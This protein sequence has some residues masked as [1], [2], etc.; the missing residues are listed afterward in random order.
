MRSYRVANIA[1]YR[2]AG[3]GLALWYEELRW[4]GWR[5]VV[6]ALESD[7]G[8]HVWP[9]LVMAGPDLGERSQRP[10][11]VDEL[12]ET[13]MQLAAELEGVPDGANIRLV[14]PAGNIDDG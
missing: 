9:P 13:G 8:L 12:W 1:A 7:R 10:V 2:H 5:E 6:R 11:P 4:P 14:L 3:D